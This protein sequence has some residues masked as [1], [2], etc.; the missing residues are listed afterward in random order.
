MYFFIL[1]VFDFGQMLP[2]HKYVLI[3]DRGQLAT[4]PFLTYFLS[5]PF[6]RA[7]SVNVTGYMV[8]LCTLSDY[9]L[10]RE[11]NFPNFD[12]SRQPHSLCC[13]PSLIG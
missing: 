10:V 8:S 4:R 7:F 2:M 13:L 12:L 6:Y 11:L 9:A 5:S 3:A 1:G